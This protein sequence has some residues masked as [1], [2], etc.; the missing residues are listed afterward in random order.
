MQTLFGLQTQYLAVG[1]T[2]VLLIL[3]LAIAIIAV[4]NRFLIK[5]SL[6]NIPRRRTQ[7]ILII[8]GLM[9]SSTIVAAS[10][11]IGDTMTASI[12]NAVL[13]GVGDT[14][15][16]ISKPVFGQLGDRT[17]TADEIEE[18]A[19]ILYDDERV[20]GIMPTNTQNA[21]VLNQRTR[22]TETRATVRGFNVAGAVGNFK[23]ESQGGPSADSRLS[24]FDLKPTIDGE[25]IDFGSLGRR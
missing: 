6:R 12:R 16:T 4:R 9:L 19:T 21:P 11:A 20:D 8:V 2:A 22:L 3:I 17:I 10:L 5:L 23:P 15:I 25:T 18:V 1:L 24:K 14:D 13:D 7:S